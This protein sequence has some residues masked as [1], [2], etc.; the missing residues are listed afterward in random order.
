MDRA[1]HHGHNV[2]EILLT[3]AGAII[4]RKGGDIVVR[5]YKGRMAMA[6]SVRIRGQRYSVAYAPTTKKVEVRKMGKGSQVLE[7]HAFDNSSTPSDV[8]RF[9]KDL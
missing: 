6:M 8:L 4:W 2:Q 7:R 9:F 1:F 3:L 5:E